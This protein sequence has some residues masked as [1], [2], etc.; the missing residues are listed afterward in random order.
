MRWVF[1]SLVCLNLLVMVWFWRDQAGMSEAQQQVDK[2]ELQG[3][4]LILL[5]ELD[6]SQLSYKTKQVSENSITD[7]RCYSVGPFKDVSDAKF[8]G[9]RA[10]ALG[11]SSQMRSLATGG[12]IEHW[13]HIPPLANRQQSLQ[14]LRELQGRGVDSYIITQGDLAEGI[15]LGLFRNK[16]S[17]DSLSKKMQA[18]NYNVVIKEVLRG[19]KELWLE[20]PQVSA[21][22]EAMRK[23]VAGE[24]QPLNWMLTDCSNSK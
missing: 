16:Q 14:L 8:L 1:L 12:S 3:K 6:R 23:R 21:L 11:F 9:I 19:E 4:G 18:M 10:E 2:V 22:T 15:S 17:A 7:Q 13:V 24:G 20:F 5:S